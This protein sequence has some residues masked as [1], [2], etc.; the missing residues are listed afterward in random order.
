MRYQNFTARCP[1]GFALGLVRCEE[2]AGRWDVGRGGAKIE[3]R[4]GQRYTHRE[5]RSNEE[6]PL[7]SYRGRA[8]K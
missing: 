2:C 6:R 3:P 1:H 5:R 7:G 4:N 8:A